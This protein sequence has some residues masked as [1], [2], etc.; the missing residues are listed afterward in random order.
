[1]LLYKPDKNA[2]EWKALAAACEAR[3]T[4]PVELLDACGAIPSTHDYHFD[5]F[6]AEAFP[7]GLAFPPWGNAAALPELPMAPVRAFS[8]DDA[9]TTEI[10]D[11]FS[12][13][14]LANGNYEVGIHIACP[15]LAIP[16]DSALDRIARA[17]LV[18]RVHA[19]AQAHDAAR[20]GGRRVHAEGRRRRRRR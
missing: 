1:M 13:R 12:V 20:R 4:N 17:R 16:R 2:L 7:Q 3:K 15:A 11:A 9:T 18:D 5:A 19:R 10:D 14:E 6:V 8:I